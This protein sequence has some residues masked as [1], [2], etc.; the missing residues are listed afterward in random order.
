MKN[1]FDGIADQIKLAQQLDSLDQLTVPLI[2]NSCAFKSKIDRFSQSDMMKK[3]A[4]PGPGSYEL[5][6]GSMIEREKSGTQ[7]SF[8][9]AHIKSAT[10]MSRL[11][12]LNPPS[13]PSHMN[14]F[15]YDE[16]EQGHLIK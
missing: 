15:G 10:S 16:N 5:S 6:R 4:L 13:I 7:L 12:V 1:G 8:Q 9:N 3:A 11:K 14:K 2:R